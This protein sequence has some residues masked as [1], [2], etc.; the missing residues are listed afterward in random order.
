MNPKK[1]YWLTAVASVIGKQ[2]RV[3]YNEAQIS[4]SFA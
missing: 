3:K 1:V 2:K 4:F